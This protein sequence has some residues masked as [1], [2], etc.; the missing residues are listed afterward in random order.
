MPS[1]TPCHVRTVSLGWAFGLGVGG[2]RAVPWTEIF[3]FLLRTAL[4]DRPQGTINRQPPTV[5]VYRPLA[6]KLERST[7]FGL[8]MRILTHLI[9]H[10]PLMPHEQRQR[11]SS[12]WLGASANNWDSI[13]KALN[14][15]R[16]FKVP[17]QGALSESCHAPNKI[18]HQNNFPRM[19]LMGGGVR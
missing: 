16:L 17:V 6:Y 9:L 10:C 13:S 1:H 5:A 11:N 7:H 12:P 18:T 3:C 4:P 19:I 2:G 14:A 8:W 15:M